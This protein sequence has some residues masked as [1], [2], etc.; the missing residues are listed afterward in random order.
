MAPILSVTIIHLFSNNRYSIY[1]DL[2]FAC[3][4]PSGPQYFLAVLP[5]TFN[6]AT[7]FNL[8]NTQTTE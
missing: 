4:L 3:L 5:C 2:T 8:A 6:K 7:V 1:R